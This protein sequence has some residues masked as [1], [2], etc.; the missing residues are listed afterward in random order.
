[1]K[2]YCNFNNCI[3]TT[4]PNNLPVVQSELSVPI[5]IEVSELAYKLVHGRNVRPAA[6]HGTSDSDFESQQLFLVDFDNTDRRKQPFPPEKIVSPQKAVQM[7]SDSGLKPCFG[8]FTF[9]H[10]G[11]VPKFRLAFLTDRP[12]TDINDRNKVQ[13]AIMQVFDGLI[14]ASCKNASR[15]FF[16]S[17][18][19]SLIYSDFDAV[20]STDE[21]LDREI[22][23]PVT[24]RMK[25]KKA[26]KSGTSVS[27]SIPSRFRNP[28]AS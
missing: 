26:A 28:A 16:G 18:S 6:M 21:L 20:N 19:G 1:M 14:D 22:L 17:Q 9:S 25:P 11:T 27:F 3:Y 13:L 23:K 10:S 7:A 2:I 5:E 8:Y 15:I 4:K 12:V 24:Q